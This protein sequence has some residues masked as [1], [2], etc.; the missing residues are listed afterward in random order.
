LFKFCSDILCKE[1]KRSSD[2][3]KQQYFFHVVC[4]NAESITGRTRVDS[5][6]VK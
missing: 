4:L 5:T 1:I 3:N 2:A 6:K